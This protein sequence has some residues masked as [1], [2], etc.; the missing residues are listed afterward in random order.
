MLEC[1]QIVS[2]VRIFRGELFD[3]ADF[4]VYSFDTRPFCARAEKPASAPD[5]ARSV[6][7]VSGNQ[8]LHALS[9]AQIRSDYNMLG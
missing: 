8:K 9:S 4:N 6:K 2:D 5:N 7:C 1:S 3:I